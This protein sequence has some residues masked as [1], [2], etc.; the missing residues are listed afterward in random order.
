M[1]HE[2][3]FC[4]FGGARE[5]GRLA[6]GFKAK[7]RI[8]LDCGIKLGQRVEYPLPELYDFFGKQ[9]EVDV[10]VTHAHLDHCGFLPHMIKK[11]RLRIHTTKPTRDLMGVLLADYLRLQKLR[12]EEVSFDS[13]DV[14]K[15]LSSVVMHNYGPLRDTPY[16]T[17][18]HNA[19][20]ILGSAMFLFRIGR[21]RVLFTGDICSRNTRILDGAEH[22][23]KADVLICESTYAH[24]N[25]PNT[26]DEI[27]KLI[28][29]INETIA[30]GGHV[31]IPSFAVG[32]AQEILLTLDDYMRSGALEKVPIFIDGMVGKAMR[33]YRQNV[34]FASDRI[35]MRIL[36]SDDD[37]FKSKF[38]HVPRNKE[39]KDV[40]RQ[41]AI[42]V[43]TSGML[44]GGPSVFYLEKLAKDE[45]N[46]L[47]IVGY[48]A[49][50]TIGRTLLEGERKVMLG[51]EEIE[52]KMR[53]EQVR[54]SGHADRNELVRF[55]KSIRGLK[56]V[57][58][59]HGERSEEL[60]DTLG[61]YEV[62][63]PKNGESYE[64]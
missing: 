34:I 46:T 10:F 51:E 4:F 64:V 19:G 6:V 26:K 15:T 38:F 33:I 40:F 49:E 43:S 17:S 48:Q 8:L 14:Q 50:G 9:E 27:K 61:E 22:G 32:R 21:K 2:M 63:I 55:I 56:S 7:K 16:H 47:I 53:V 54:V 18:A 52:V 39:R 30:Q 31:L 3:E 35:K 11:K 36:T 25:L 23:L 41:P 1:V 44:V 45:R 42:I 24:E 57:F 5:V 12:E 28:K 37:P 29:I 58:L 62:F 59:V 13:D 20:H 60:L